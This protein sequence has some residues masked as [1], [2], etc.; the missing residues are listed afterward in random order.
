MNSS[1]KQIQDAS[2]QMPLSAEYNWNNVYYVYSADEGLQ[3]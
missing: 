2:A 3:A 1:Y